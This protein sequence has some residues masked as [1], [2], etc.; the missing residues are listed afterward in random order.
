MKHIIFLLNIATLLFGLYSCNSPQKE[1]EKIK[2]QN[3]IGQLEQFIKKYPKSE[4]ANNAKFIR[5]SL[6]YNRIKGKG[7]IDSLKW[8]NS[9]YPES[10]FIE[11]SEKLIDSLN[12]EFLCEKD[13]IH[14]IEVFL[15][16]NPQSRFAEKAKE[17]ITDLLLMEVLKDASKLA[18]EASGTKDNVRASNLFVKTGKAYLNALKIIK[19]DSI[20]LYVRAAYSYYKA[21][22]R[23]Q[24]QIQVAF[25]GSLKK[26]T[27]FDKAADIMRNAEVAMTPYRNKRTELYKKAITYYEKAKSTSQANKMKNHNEVLK[28][29]DEEIEQEWG[30]N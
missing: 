13:S 2:D 5:D 29:K 14:L 10:L 4:F 7:I 24:N 3:A 8:F 1:F 18:K 21:S 30:I 25:D 19:S 23:M 17:K 6:V 20:C 12:F 27:K 22:I 16:E 15:N 11:D 9:K 26:V 28:F